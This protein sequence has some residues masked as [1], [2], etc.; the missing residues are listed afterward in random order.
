M[1]KA[2][3]NMRKTVQQNDLRVEHDSSNQGKVLNL[4]HKYPIPEKGSGYVYKR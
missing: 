4:N 2:Q 1:E 3:L